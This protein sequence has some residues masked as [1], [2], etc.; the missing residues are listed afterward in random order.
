MS[1]L[2]GPL[3]SLELIVADVWSETECLP[4]GCQAEVAKPPNTKS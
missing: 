1:M 4:A 3:L 2:N